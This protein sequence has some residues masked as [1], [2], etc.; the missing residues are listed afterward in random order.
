[1][2][3]IVFDASLDSVLQDRACN[4][5]REHKLKC[6]R[7]VPCGTCQRKTIACIYDNTSA[8]SRKKR[9]I[10]NYNNE[11]S[12][13]TE[14][15]SVAIAPPQLEEQQVSN[16]DDSQQLSPTQQF[17]A[18]PHTNYEPNSLYQWTGDQVIDV[19]DYA[20]LWHDNDIS[21]NID[22]GF[23]LF[24]ESAPNEAF[25]PAGINMELVERL[26]L[27]YIGQINPSM[28]VLRPQFLLDGLSTGRF[29]R[30]RDFAA[31]LLAVCAFICLQSHAATRSAAL[32]KQFL[33]EA[34][35][36]Y[37]TASLGENPSVETVLACFLIFGSLWTLGSDN[38]AWLRL[39]EVINLAR[40]LKIDQLRDP[41]QDEDWQSKMQVYLGLVVVERFVASS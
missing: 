34:I 6:D 17:S 40:I 1:M 2:H 36:L 25:W 20:D 30:A 37:N 23:G 26:V 10:D 29:L 41:G 9:R 32:A 4:K 5:C 18:I 3:E 39:Q 27:T 15:A 8:S 28:P 38:A 24:K 11:V 33:T 12:A 19:F 14:E 35:S 21:C 16:F 31:C 7:R 22:L 13:I